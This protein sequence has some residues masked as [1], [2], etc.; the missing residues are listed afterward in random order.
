LLGTDRLVPFPWYAS[1]K[2]NYKIAVTV[3]RFERDDAGSTQ[4]AAAWLIRDGLTDKL[5]ISR[6][7]NINQGAGAQ[8]KVAGSSMDATAAALS[9]DLS[10]LSKQIADAV[11]ELKSTHPIARAIDS[12]AN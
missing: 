6:H 5:L 3:E 7:S 10:S 12:P 2:L 8:G 11:L 9:A 4:L 1:V